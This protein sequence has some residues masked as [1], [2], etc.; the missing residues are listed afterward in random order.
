MK[1]LRLKTKL[2]IRERERCPEDV[3]NAFTCLVEYVISFS[4]NVYSTKLMC[5]LKY[6]LVH[7]FL[8]GQFGIVSQK[9][10]DNPKKIWICQRIL[11]LLKCAWR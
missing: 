11:V 2:S 7:L 5:L 4:I 9:M 8:L 1:L 3:L 10:Y 6:I